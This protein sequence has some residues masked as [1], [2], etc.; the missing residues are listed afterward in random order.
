MNVLFWEVLKFCI[1]GFPCYYICVL[2][3]R[4]CLLVYVCVRN[5]KGSTAA[6]QPRVSLN[7]ISILEL[8]ADV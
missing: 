2:C 6:R 5:L 7:K 4:L 8:S 1:T 3:V